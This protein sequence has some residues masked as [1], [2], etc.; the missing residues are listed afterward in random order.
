SEVD[1]LDLIARTNTLEIEL[2]RLEQQLAHDR[3]FNAHKHAREDTSLKVKVSSS[4][5]ERTLKML[6]CVWGKCDE[7]KAYLAEKSSQW[8]PVSTHEDT[9]MEFNCSGL[10]RLG[11]DFARYSLDGGGYL[12]LK[13]LLFVVLMANIIERISSWTGGGS[14][15]E[16]TLTTLRELLA[17]VTAPRSSVHGDDLIKGVRMCFEVHRS[18]KS[19]EL[20]QRTAQ[21]VLTQILHATVQRAEMSPA[22]ILAEQ[23]KATSTSGSGSAGGGEASRRSNSASSSGE[24][25]SEEERSKQQH[26]WIESQVDQWLDEAV[27]KV[28]PS[29]PNE[30]GEAPK[31]FGFCIVCRN[32]APHYCL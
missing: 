2:R 14:D 10:V 26:E 6:I 17:A 9:R 19:S 11:E 25:L 28:D 15:D 30:R 22:D 27:A 21:A 5:A 13:H 31:K 8:E 20:A 4:A 7:G 12:M 23:R 3:D 1:R 24:E 18:P 16:Q 29:A 32:P